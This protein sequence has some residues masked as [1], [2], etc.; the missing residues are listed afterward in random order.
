MDDTTHLPDPD[1]IEA[2][3]E[4]AMP[5]EGFGPSTAERLTRAV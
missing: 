5:G 3:F 1:A 2:R 4:V